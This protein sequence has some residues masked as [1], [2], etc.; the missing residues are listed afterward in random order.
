MEKFPPSSDDR[1][2]GIVAC[3]IALIVVPS[4]AVA[5]RLWSRG[6]AASLT[7]WWD[8]VAI[9]VTLVFSHAFLALALY[10][11]T[12]GLGKHSRT[13]PLE[14]V[15]L[16][17]TVNRVTLVFYSACIL[18][19]KFSALLLY[20]RIFKSSPVF[21]RTLWI[22]GVIL[23]V[24]W[25][26]LTLVPWLFCHPIEK[27]LNVFLPGVCDHPL[28]WYYAS[29]LINAVADLVVLI[30]PTPI[31]WKLQMTMRKKISISLV[32]LIGYVSAFL[33]FARFII[34]VLNPSILNGGQGADPSWDLVP[35]LYLS[36]LEAPVAII[37]LCAP[38]ISQL[39]SRAV[40]HGA[41]SSLFH[42]RPQSTSQGSSGMERKD[43]DNSNGS[44]LVTLDSS[45]NRS[46]INRPKWANA[47]HNTTVSTT[48]TLDED[49][50]Q[51][52]SGDV[53]LG[54]IHVKDRYDVVHQQV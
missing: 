35:L 19:L 26:I 15:N 7:F 2:P 31:I 13:I 9:L 14:L 3:C 18:F 12:I 20:A 34:I 4:I 43:S 41:F 45:A 48:R 16:N 27:D 25:A 32:F 37:A 50:N 47:S 51:F 28:S 36:L 52:E 22:V 5:L 8:D 44:G 23:T 54:A 11:T 10:W 40:E 1:A 46:W 6:V 53:A 30:L 42:S 17:N 29:A 33:S 39:V 21:R 24:W 49:G 38:S